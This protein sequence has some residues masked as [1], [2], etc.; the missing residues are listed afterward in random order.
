MTGVDRR[1]KVAGNHGQ[2]PVAARIGAAA[3]I[4]VDDSR[5]NFGST[6]VDAR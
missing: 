1:P 6:V 3:S 4:A 2:S 5:V